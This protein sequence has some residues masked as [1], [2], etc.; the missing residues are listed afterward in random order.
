MFCYL[1][2]QLEGIPWV[3]SCEPL[4]LFD[5]AWDF[6]KILKENVSKL[7]GKMMWTSRW[8]VGVPVDNSSGGICRLFVSPRGEGDCRHLFCRFLSC[9]CSYSG[10]LSSVSTLAGQYNCPLSLCKLIGHGIPKRLRKLP[11][12]ILSFG[13]PKGKNDGTMVW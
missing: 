4:A 10:S 2:V 6:S 3:C 5:V 9:L 11:V 12:Q 7:L 13:V 8:H 1:P